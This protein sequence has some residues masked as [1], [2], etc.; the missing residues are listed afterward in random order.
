MRTR[1]AKRF[2][3]FVLLLIA[4]FAI[5]VAWSWPWAKD[6]VQSN[7]SFFKLIGLGFGPVLA[8]IGFFYGL[9]DKAEIKDITEELGKA[10]QAAE[11]EHN[12]AE[13]AR[14]EVQRKLETIDRL[15]TD[16]ATIA[17]AG[18]LWKLR[19]N[20][21]F[22]EYRAWKYDPEG[23]K[24]VTFG[25]FKGGVGKTHLAANFAAYVSEYQQKPVLLIDLDYQGSLSTT[26]LTAADIEP[27]GSQV[28]RFF[29]ENADLVTLASNRTH[30][31]HSGPGVALNHGRGLA[32]C[33][34]AASDYPLSELESKLLVSRVLDGEFGLDERYRLAHLLLQ[35]AVRRDYSI[36]IIDTPP[37]MTLGTVNAFVASHYVVVPTILD[38]V[39]SEAVV[40]FLKQV[41]TLRADLDLDLRLAA[42]VGMMTRTSMLNA[43]EQRYLDHAISAAREIGPIARDDFD[44]ATIPRKVQVTNEA[45]L[46]Y[47]LSD[48]NGPLA[49]QFYN[50]LFNK[51]WTR[52]TGQA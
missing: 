44:V 27:V 34:L 32:K 49:S 14:L 6:L 3:H 12:D 11:D 43:T 13:R 30:L 20:K 41:E 45:D 39:S 51:L 46:A 37:R 17:N 23:A 22:A 50:P 26:V 19:E 29:D 15:R 10:K 28:D 7:E 16:L 5:Y 2:L 33:W 31:A 48:N 42:I 8:L 52:I 18:R 1:S 35:P 40:P 21:P 9:V 38:R 25:L 24:I 36:I 47:F 4:A